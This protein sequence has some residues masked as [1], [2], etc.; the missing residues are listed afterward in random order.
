MQVKIEVCKWA[1]F[2]RRMSQSN[3][4]DDEGDQKMESKVQVKIIMWV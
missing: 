2:S 1:W 3:D 4:A